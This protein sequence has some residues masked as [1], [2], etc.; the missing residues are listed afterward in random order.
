MLKPLLKELSLL[1]KELENLKK[2]EIKKL[3]S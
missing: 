3:P 2:E 1:V